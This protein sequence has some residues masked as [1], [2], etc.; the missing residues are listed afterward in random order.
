MS[1]F[2]RLFSRSAQNA[3]HRGMDAYNRGEYEVAIESLERVL[4]SESQNS[5]IYVLSRFYVTH[6]RVHLGLS[7]LERERYDD[8][9][10]TFLEV[11]KRNPDYP[12]VHLYLGRIAE[13][14]QLWR[15]AEMRY[16][17]A[18]MINAS[19][20]EPRLAL[21]LLYRSMGRHPESVV[22][23]AH[24]AESGI[25]L[26]ES[27]LRGTPEP[28]SPE[29][30]ATFTK[31]VH[32]PRGNSELL[33]DGLR[34]YQEGRLEEALEAFS[35]AVESAPAHPDVLCR[36][37]TVL[38]ELGRFNDAI[39]DLTRAL[40]HNPGYQEAR[41]KRGVAYFQMKRFLEASRDFEILCETDP[42][43][44]ETRLLLGM[45]Y[46]KAD[47]IKDAVDHLVQAAS[48]KSAAGR[49]HYFLALSYVALER[50][51][52][53]INVLAPIQLPTCRALL[54]RL[55]LE[56]NRNADAVAALEEAIQGGLHSGDLQL[57]LGRALYQVGRVDEAR[58]KATDALDDPAT[59]DAGALLLAQMAFDAGDDA[60]ALDRLGRLGSHDY[61]ALVLRGRVL[62]R[63]DRLPE[64]EAVLQ[65]ALELRPDAEDAKR[66]LG[67]VWRRAGKRDESS[68]LLR[69]ATRDPADALFRTNEMPDVKAPWKMIG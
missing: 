3:Y 67:L 9:H 25:E 47:R 31:M 1:L 17:R 61:H 8:A 37:A 33:A 50:R 56:T 35:Q 60:E 66:A 48:H 23:M 42:Q 32:T 21:A 53:A 15:E 44:A 46:Y 2:S 57:T 55:Y 43:N 7:Y 29:V 5:P 10:A 4:A 20:R 14:R 6:G 26:P 63:M 65:K 49:A 28:D 22:H 62:G 64:A 19:Y 36:R 38:A 18:L 51:D 40:E 69:D 12:D 27:W 54:G 13:R 34:R 68:T 58:R 52:R 11:I 41:L 24:L 45:S 59:A 16:K 30:V 39:E